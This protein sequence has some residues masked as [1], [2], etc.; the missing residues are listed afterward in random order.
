MQSPAY[1][2]YLGRPKM[3]SGKRALEQIPAELE[4]YGA[5][6]PLVMVEGAT[7]GVGA[8]ITKA[9]YDSNLVI[10]ALF[11]GHVAGSTSGIV[12]E[13]AGLHAARKCDSIVVAGGGPL[14]DAAKCVNIELTQK[15]A[16]IQ[17]SGENKIP[18]ELG[19]FVLVPVALVSGYEASRYAFIDGKMCGSDFL[20]PDM[21]IID[22]RA[23]SKAAPAQTLSSGLIALA[24]AIEAILSPQANPIMGSY[25]YA[26]IR[27]LSENL[28]AAVRKPKDGKKSVAVA[29]GCAIA[30]TAFSN[31][32]A[33]V[34]HCLAEALSDAT[35]VDP[36]VYM[37]I[38][39]RSLVRKRMEDK[40]GLGDELCLALSGPAVY[41]VSEAKRRPEAALQSLNSVFG[42]LG[43]AV[44]ADLAATGTPG[45]QLGPAAKKA[46]KASSTKLSEKECMDLLERAWGGK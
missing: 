18:K 7:P 19:P 34:V 22:S 35:G 40:A 30:A 41:S 28:P 32:P 42:E 8:A 11:D 33:G 45:G 37:G 21:V 27:L 29:N 23:S 44:P 26:A 43:N 46:V 17:F 20:S 1:Y 10:G 14:V 39:V 4:G 16:A 2:E 25:A 3:I 6:R 9:M 12:R 31:A 38:L 13:L 36:G 24:H 5:S 15:K